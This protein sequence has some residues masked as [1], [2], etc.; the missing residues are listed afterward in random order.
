MKICR[1]TYGDSEDP[2]ASASTQSDQDLHC[3]LIESLGTV[4][5]M[6]KY[7]S[8]LD[9]TMFLVHQIRKSFKIQNKF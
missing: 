7:S 9:Q 3:S 1:R 2:D 5:Q 4:E 6:T 8:V